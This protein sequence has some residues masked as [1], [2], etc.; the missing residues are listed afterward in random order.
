M[1][2]RGNLQS[3]TLAST[4]GGLQAKDIKKTLVPEGKQ[5]PISWL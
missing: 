4:Q 1:E 2:V 5:T 3:K